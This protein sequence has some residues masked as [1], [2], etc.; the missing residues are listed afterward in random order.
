MQ[1]C[2]TGIFLIV[3]VSAFVTAR[4]VRDT[5]DMGQEGVGKGDKKNS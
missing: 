2:S 5:G 3:K 4:S 1:E